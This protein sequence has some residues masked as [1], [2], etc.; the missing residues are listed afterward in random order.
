M[1]KDTSHPYYGSTR[2]FPAIK[3]IFEAEVRL[4]R[5][6]IEQNVDGTEE[7]N[8]YEFERISIDWES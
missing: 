5:L 8:C 7:K 2:K 6:W 4:E 3:L 1:L